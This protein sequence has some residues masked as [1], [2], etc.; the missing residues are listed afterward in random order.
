V[1]ADHGNRQTSSIGFN[2][3][4]IS[5]LG[6]RYAKSDCALHDDVLETSA[7]SAAISGISIKEAAEN[8]P[9]LLR[10]VSVLELK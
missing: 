4:R 9:E 10:A 6:A 2:K 8:N 5:T 3:R 7:V 1:L